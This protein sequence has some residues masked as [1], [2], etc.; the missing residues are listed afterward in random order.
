MRILVTGAAGFIGS[1]TSGRCSPAAMTS[2]VSTTSMAV[3]MSTSS[4]P[5]WRGCGTRRFSVVEADLADLGMTSGCLR[6]TSRERVVHLAAQAGVRYR[7]HPHAYA[8]SNL[9]GFLQRAGRLPPRARRS[10]SSMLRPARSTAPTRSM[11]FCVHDDVDH[12]VSLYAA[13]KKANELMAHSYAP[14]L[15]PAGDGPA[16]LHGLRPVGPARHG[17]VP[18]HRRHPR[19]RADRRLHHGDQRATS[20]IST[21]SSRAW[22]A[23]STACATPESGWDGDGAGPGHV[24]RAVSALQYRQ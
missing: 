12:P 3:M 24:V 9:V 2:S 1:H 15:R 10:I 21:T 6:R 20:P 17:A 19:R 16:L 11:P 8:D 4:L 22:C 18:V 13:T 23:R 14:S 7:R 5:V